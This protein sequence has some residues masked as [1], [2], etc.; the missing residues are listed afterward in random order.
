MGS[1]NER[2][3]KDG[4]MMVENINYDCYGYCAICHMCLIQT[5]IENGKPTDVWLGNKTEMT[6]K[7]NDASLMRVTVCKSCEKCYNQK[8]HS[9][10]LMK[11]IIDG[12]EVETEKLVNDKSK[13]HFDREW[14]KKHMAIYSKKEL[15]GRVETGKR[16][17]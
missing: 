14:K 15:V 5:I 16:G 7:L 2:L 8:R 6:F 12:W 1:S 17:R 13:P 10:R 3:D 11:S 4:F 9:K